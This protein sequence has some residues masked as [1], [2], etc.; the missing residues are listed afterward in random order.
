MKRGLTCVTVC[1][2]P[3]PPAG[4]SA[5]FAPP[6]SSSARQTWPFFFFLRMARGRRPTDHDDHSGGFHFRLG[7][8][9]PQLALQEVPSQPVDRA[10][11][12][13]VPS[14]TFRRQP[15]LQ[16]AAVFGPDELCQEAVDPRTRALEVLAVL[17][18]LPPATAPSLM[19]FCL[20]CH[21]RRSCCLAATLLRTGAFS[22]A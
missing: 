13:V 15:L 11:E 10:T 6:L 5:G 17:S 14:R 16:A 12:P 22:A 1:L 2:A 3:R 8:P 20:G 21:R 18:K 7:G 19:R 4:G 9:R